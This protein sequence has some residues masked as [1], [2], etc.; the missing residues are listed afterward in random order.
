MVSS[1]VRRFNSLSVP[2]SGDGS[3]EVWPIDKD[4]DPADRPGGCGAG[5]GLGRV[6]LGGSEEVEVVELF[7][8]WL[9]ASVSIFRFSHVV[10]FY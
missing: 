2:D 6:Y 8:A 5:L 7:T 3:S 1:T 4:Q 10:W 9:K